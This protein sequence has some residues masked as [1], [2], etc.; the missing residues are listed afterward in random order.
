MKPICTGCNKPASEIDEY[1]ES[2]K[3]YGLTVE[4]YV[5]EE[6]GTYNP[7]NGHFLCTN[8]YINAGLP[9]LPYPKQWV[10]P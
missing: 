4:Q 5:A 2:A 8:C 1:I 9:S 6:E 7:T 3:E 10:A